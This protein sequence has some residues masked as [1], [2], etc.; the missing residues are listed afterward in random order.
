M[1]RQPIKREALYDW[2]WR[3][4]FIAVLL[5][6]VQSLLLYKNSFLSYFCFYGQ[7]SSIPVTLGIVLALVASWKEGRIKKVLFPFFIFAL[8]YLFICSVVALH[9]ILENAAPGFYTAENFGETPK[10]AL[11]KSLLLSLGIENNTFLYGLIIFIRDVRQGVH[12]VFFAFG[13]AVWIASLYCKDGIRLF[14]VVRK[15]VVGSFVLLT[16]YVALEVAHLYG[17]G[18]ATAVL[19]S[20]NACLYEPGHF[21]GWYPPIVSPNQVRGT[22]TEPAYFAIWLS[23]A[24]PFLISFSFKTGAIGIKRTFANCVVFT[25]LFSVWLMTYSRTSIVL[26]AALFTLYFFFAVIFRTR[27]NRSKL[28]ILIL[29]FGI[30]YSLVSTWGPQERGRVK[31]APV[32]VVPVQKSI[33][34]ELQESGKV[35]PI[36][37]ANA[38]AGASVSKNEEKVEILSNLTESRLFQNTVKSSVDAESRSNPTRVQDFLLKIEVFKDHPFLGASDTLGSVAQARKMIERPDILTAESRQRL[39]YTKTNGLFM[40]GVGGNSLSIGG[41]LSSRGLLGFL[42]SFG[43]V[44]LLGIILFV[45]IFKF[46]AVLRKR[47]ICIFVS[48]VVVFLSSF[49]QG[50][51]FFYFWCVA[52]IALGMVCFEGRGK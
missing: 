44:V 14:N 22:W 48:S 39:G 35:A 41:M 18:G 36:A 42:V 13:F 45:K 19:K 50:L 29:S 38:N 15:A 2:Q 5:F 3:L 4:L 10:I 16:P 37:N 33:P 31:I 11:I 24:V 6:P 1:L 20:I 40:S 28:L 7:I 49:T 25:V 21:L 26:I 47:A 52:G 12:E 17:I 32:V 9:S 23:F 8:V 27:E 46:S 34:P 43:P 51:W 30:A